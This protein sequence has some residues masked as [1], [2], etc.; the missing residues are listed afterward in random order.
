[1]TDTN[2]KGHKTEVISDEPV[3]AVVV[4]LADAATM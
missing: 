1:M 3:D 2:G 4:L